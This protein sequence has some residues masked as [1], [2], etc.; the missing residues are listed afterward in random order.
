GWMARRAIS[1]SDEWRAS[2]SCASR[3]RG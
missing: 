1:E 3:R 2:V